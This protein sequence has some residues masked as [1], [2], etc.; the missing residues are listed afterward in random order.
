MS[1]WYGFGSFS[2]LSGPILLRFRLCY[3]SKSCFLIL[4]EI[5]IRFPSDFAILSIT[6]DFIWFVYQPDTDLERSLWSVNKNEK[7]AAMVPDQEEK[8]NHTD[9]DPDTDAGARKR[10]RGRQRGFKMKKNRKRTA[11]SWWMSYSNYSRSSNS[12]TIRLSKAK[13]WCGIVKQS[14]A[15]QN[16]FTEHEAR[17]KSVSGWYTNQI[18]AWVML[19]MRKSDVK[20]WC[21]FRSKLENMIWSCK[22]IEI[23]AESIHWAWRTIRISISLTPGHILSDAQNDT[24]WRGNLMWIS[25][26]IRKY[27]LGLWCSR[28]LSRI[29]PPSA[30]NDPKPYRDDFGA[31]FK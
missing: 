5:H 20:I 31:I 14:K 17:S 15:E 7:E 18:K 4:V 22:R 26:K 8:I 24:I 21:G 23:W 19:R 11:G 6:L 28:N 30:E 27:Y 2:T 9:S 10:K 12:D 3:K 1:S 16:Q 13:V 29:G 25:T